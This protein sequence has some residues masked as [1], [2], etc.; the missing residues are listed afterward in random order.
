[1]RAH[2]CWFLLFCCATVTGLSPLE[3]EDP[4]P[5]S[6]G[7]NAEATAERPLSALIV[8]D[9]EGKTTALRV[10]GARQLA[11]LESYFPSYRMAPEGATPGAWD[12]KYEIYLN[13]AEGRSNRI[14]V[15]ANSR[16]WSMGRGDF[17]LRG[18]FSDFVAALLKP[19]R[20]QPKE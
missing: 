12:A 8:F 14:L 6:R 2:A 17:E 3:A 9:H 18:Y 4:P 20:G 7:P 1:M 5:K 19:P 16:Y 10:A 11:I 13:F 15:S